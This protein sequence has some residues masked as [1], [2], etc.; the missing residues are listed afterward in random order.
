M[1]SKE[2]TIKNNAEIKKVVLVLVLAL[3]LGIIVLVPTLMLRLEWATDIVSCLC[4]GFIIFY[5]GMKLTPLLN[6]RKLLKGVE[7]G[8][9]HDMVAD[10]VSI[11]PDM[12]THDG[13]DCH[14][15]EVSEGPREKGDDIR[16]FYWDDSK[17]MP[18]IKEGETLRVR[19][20]G[21][22]V[23]EWERV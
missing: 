9:Y 16:M 7:S 17:P 2:D 23:I 8:I 13:V 14:V 4:V 18:D 22:F 5:W 15:F 20:H 21:G 11:S 3:A 10:F 12:S 1:Y 6:Y 19:S